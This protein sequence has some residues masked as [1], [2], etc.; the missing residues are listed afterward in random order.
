MVVLIPH[1]LALSALARSSR[2]EP[3]YS[4]QWFIALARAQTLAH[5]YVFHLTLSEL[6]PSKTHTHI[7]QHQR[8]YVLYSRLVLYF[9]RALAIYTY[10]IHG[11]QALYA[12]PINSIHSALAK[13]KMHRGGDVILAVHKIHLFTLGN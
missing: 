8:L 12:I 5:P 1:A 4:S 3:L 11:L 9:C 6:Y 10:T 2:P 13:R 7:Q